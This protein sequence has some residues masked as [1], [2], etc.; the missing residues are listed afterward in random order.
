MQT[1]RY[2]PFSLCSKPLNRISR[3]LAGNAEL[4]GILLCFSTTYSKIKINI[5]KGS[6]IYSYLPFLTLS[7]NVRDKYFNIVLHNDGDLSMCIKFL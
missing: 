6:R 1:I 3:K 7:I 2:V 4:N 5:Q